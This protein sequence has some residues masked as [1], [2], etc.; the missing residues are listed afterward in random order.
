M[1]NDCKKHQ[2]K[3]LFDCIGLDHFRGRTARVEMK[4]AILESSA[5]IWITEGA[6]V[7]IL[8]RNTT[9]RLDPKFVHALLV[10]KEASKQALKNCGVPTLIQH[11]RIHYPSCVF[12]H[13]ESKSSSI[14]FGRSFGSSR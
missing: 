3:R 12:R 1:T 2:E 6:L 5:K 4:S 10:Y 7:E 9:I 14:E 13:M 8:R 11:S